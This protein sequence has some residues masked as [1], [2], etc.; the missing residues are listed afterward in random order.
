MNLTFFAFFFRLVTVV[1]EAVISDAEAVISDAVD[2]SFVTT[3]APFIIVSISGTGA[4]QLDNIR[5][6]HNHCSSAV[7]YVV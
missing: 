6:Y 7:S 4:I 1:T 3:V 2:D 5:M